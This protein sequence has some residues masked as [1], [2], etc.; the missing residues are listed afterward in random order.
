MNDRAGPSTFAR[1]C[2]FGVVGFVVDAGVLTVLVNGY[3][4]HPYSSRAVSFA[5]AVTVTWLLNRTWAFARTANAR[6]EYLRYAAIQ[7]VGA[8]INLATFVAAIEIAPPLGTIP[9]IPLAIGAA[10]ALVFNY[11]ASRFFVFRHR[12]IAVGTANS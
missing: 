1:F 10:P 9:A 12:G 5:L 7:L 2:A 11:L 8:L 3:S 6:S 4:W